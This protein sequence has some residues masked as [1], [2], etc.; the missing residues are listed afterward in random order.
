MSDKI[1]ETA[2]QYGDLLD[3]PDHV[4]GEIVDGEL[5]VNPRPAAPH[6]R[7]SSILGTEITGPFDRGRGGP[8]GWWILFEPELHLGADVL[9]PDLAG[10]RRE[11]M[12]TIPDVAFF[13]IPPDW[14]CEVVSPRTVRLDRTRKMP[15]YARHGV[16]FLWIVDPVAKTLE[17]FVLHDGSWKLES[18]HG[19]DD[20]VRAVPFDAIELD[21][22]LL[23]LE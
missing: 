5:Y 18:A 23:W 21:L 17:A 10:W 11:R 3:L 12:P 14:I 6:A 8:G 20:T 9:V 1:K 16:S 15:A 19:G 2:P 7:A 4:V 13:E 22:S